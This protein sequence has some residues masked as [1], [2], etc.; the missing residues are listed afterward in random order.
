MKCSIRTTGLLEYYDKNNKQQM[1][2]P[3]SGFTDLIFDLKD[4]LL[5]RA[6]HDIYLFKNYRD[7][8]V[9]ELIKIN[10]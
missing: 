3:P 4:H 7:N 9:A 1:I 6:G 10:I 5:L 8:D 2:M